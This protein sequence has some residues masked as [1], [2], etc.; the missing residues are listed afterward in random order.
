M[1]VNKYI[2]RKIKMRNAINDK[3]KVIKVMSERYSDRRK[4]MNSSNLVVDQIQVASSD[5]HD[6]DSHLNK[7]ERQM[8]ATV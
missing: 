6:Y 1:V 4:K 2:F 3:I 5:L 7:R 8:V